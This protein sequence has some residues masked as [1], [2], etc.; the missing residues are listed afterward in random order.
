MSQEL[1]LAK[2][3]FAWFQEKKLRSILSKLKQYPSNKAPLSTPMASHLQK[4]L[5]KKEN[6]YY[7]PLRLEDQIEISAFFH[8]KLTNIRNENGAKHFENLSHFECEIE[9]K[10]NR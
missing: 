2:D 5:L 8:S 4:I 9:E 1:S 3:P 6:E 7:P 10:I